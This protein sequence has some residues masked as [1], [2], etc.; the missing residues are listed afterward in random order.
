MNNCVNKKTLLFL[1]KSMAFVKAA[2]RDE[3][4]IPAN[5]TMPPE[6]LNTAKSMEIPFFLMPSRLSS[7]WA[8]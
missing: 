7:Y 5:N 6:K 2:L 1:E 8:V 3:R 4:F